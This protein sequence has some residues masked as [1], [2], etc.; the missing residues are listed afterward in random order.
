[1]AEKNQTRTPTTVEK[2]L[3]V[4]TRAPQEQLLRF[5]SWTDADGEPVVFR[6]R[7]LSYNKVREIQEMNLG[8]NAGFTAAIITAGVIEPNLRDERLQRRWA[9]SH[10]MKWFTGCC[11]RARSRICRRRSKSCPATAARPCKFWR[12]SKKTERGRRDVFDVPAF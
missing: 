12:A 10:R 6:I 5:K 9:R 4:C 7:E 3:G 1:M 2:L 8:N 11:A